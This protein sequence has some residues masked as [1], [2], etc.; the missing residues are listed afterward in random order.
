MSALEG[1]HG[2][3]CCDMLR[4][5]HRFQTS[6]VAIIP[7]AKPC[8]DPNSPEKKSWLSRDGRPA[9]SGD[10]TFCTK[11]SAP[12]GL[13]RN[14]RKHRLLPALIMHMIPYTVAKIICLHGTVR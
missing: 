13:S 1:S 5:F 12:P 6:L 8:I 3:G 4:P 10:G 7:Q 9:A 14:S 11:K 2:C